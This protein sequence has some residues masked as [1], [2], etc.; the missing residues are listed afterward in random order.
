M[1]SYSRH[2]EPASPSTWRSRLNPFE[3]LK[4]EQSIDEEKAS[5][6][7]SETSEDEAEVEDGVVDVEEV[8]WEAQV[9]YCLS[10]QPQ[11]TDLLKRALCVS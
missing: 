2:Q 5:D 6:A 9:R 1:S 7:S 3:Y 11:T 10:C 8:L 4:S